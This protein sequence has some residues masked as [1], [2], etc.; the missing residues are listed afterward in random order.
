MLLDHIHFYVKNTTKTRDWLIKNMGFKLVSQ[1]INEHTHTEIVSP[2]K[3]LFFFIS[4]A[5]NIT[6]PVD[7]YL[8]HFASGVADVAFEVKNIDAIIKN[9]STLKKYIINYP[10]TY[11]LPQGKLKIAKLRGWN[12]LEHTLIENHTH[13]PFPLLIP[14]LPS[15]TNYSHLKSYL[16]NQQ[17]LTNN[18]YDLSGIDHVVLNVS[19]GKLTQVV[20][21]YQKIFG[22]K[23]GQNFNIKTDKSGLFSKVLISPHNN[24]Y[25]NINEPTSDKSQI[26]EF[27]NFNGG[28]GIQH[29]ALHSL[30]IINTVNK[31][32]KNGLEFL[33]MSDLYYSKLKKYGINGVIPDLTSSEFQEI[34]KQQILIDYH[35]DTPESLLMQIFTKPIFNQPTFF[36]EL[37]ER[38]KQ[39]QGFGAA[40]F[41]ALFE[42]IEKQ[43]LARIQ[44]V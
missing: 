44:L 7:H 19:K 1:F 9:L 23:L 34:E 26:Q 35:H 42:I 15:N 16:D 43:Q 32:R 28:S 11:I 38:R 4:S 18:N 30:N 5:I 17:Q 13:I 10:H 3:Y 22:F 31:M 12:S 39:A 2:N 24:F 21:F 14:R 37:I 25:F 36:F 8:N 6:S 41:Q 29:I 20:E 27:I 40:N 33:A